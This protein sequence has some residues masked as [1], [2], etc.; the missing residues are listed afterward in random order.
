MGKVC[1]GVLGWPKP[2]F[3]F[4]HNLLQKNLITFWPTQHNGE[5]GLPWWLKTHL[6]VLEMQVTLVRSLGQEDL[7]ENEMTTSSSILA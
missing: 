7:L 5:E 2:S 6:S 1:T 4:F 3:R